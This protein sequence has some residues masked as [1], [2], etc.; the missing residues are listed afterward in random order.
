MTQLPAVVGG[1]D[2]QA[3]PTDLDGLGIQIDAV[4][5]VLEDL[6]VEIEEGAVAAQ[7]FEPRVGNLVECLEL[8][9]SLDEERAALAH[10]P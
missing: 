9:E 3:E 5:V 7:L 1:F 4:E 2:P 10:D 8:V 6:A